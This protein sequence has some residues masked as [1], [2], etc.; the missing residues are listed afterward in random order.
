LLPGGA[1]AARRWRSR[2]GCLGDD[3]RSPITCS[4]RSSSR[5]LCAN[6]MASARP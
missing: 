4:T 2:A 3:L 1:T 6:A 5:L